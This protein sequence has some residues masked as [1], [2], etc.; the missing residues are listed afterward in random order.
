MK[1]R[2]QPIADYS[3]P[4]GRC[5]GGK[6]MFGKKMGEAGFGLCHN[7]LLYFLANHFLATSMGKKKPAI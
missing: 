3:R 2:S 6:K 5:F 1:A 4:S 7:S